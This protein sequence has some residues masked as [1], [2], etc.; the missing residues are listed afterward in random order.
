MLA[1]ENTNLLMPDTSTLFCFFFIKKHLALVAACLRDGTEPPID[2]KKL[3]KKRI[4]L[5]GKRVIL[6][7]KATMWRFYLFLWRTCQIINMTPC[8]FQTTD[9]CQNTH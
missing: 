3:W 1:V 7:D 4:Y 5:F 8:F 2:K 6:I 9:L